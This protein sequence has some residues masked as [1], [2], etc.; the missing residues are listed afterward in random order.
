M[1]I[2]IGNNDLNPWLPG[3]GSFGLYNWRQNA[4]QGN[5]LPWTAPFTN[6]AKIGH[7]VE[8]EQGSATVNGTLR[9]G[10]D[11]RLDNRRTRSA[12]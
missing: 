12:G 3:N 6:G 2:E 11:L 1:Q 4:V 8:L 7:C 9:S 10:S 5:P